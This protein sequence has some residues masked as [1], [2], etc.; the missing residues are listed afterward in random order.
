MDEHGLLSVQ[1][2]IL[3]FVPDHETGPGSDA[4]CANSLL[5]FV[6]GKLSESKSLIRPEKKIEPRL[7]EHHFRM[8]RL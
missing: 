4:E 1:L 8:F 6:H 2:L 3:C 7:L 5:L